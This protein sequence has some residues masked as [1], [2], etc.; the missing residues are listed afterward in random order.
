MIKIKRAQLK[1]YQTKI[2]KISDQLK[3][4]FIC[5]CFLRWKKRKYININEKNISKLIFEK[6]LKK[7]HT[8]RFFFKVSNLQFFSILFLHDLI[9]IWKKNETFNLKH[10]ICQSIVSFKIQN[11]VR[12]W[13]GQTFSNKTVFSLGDMFVIFR[14]DFNIIH[15]YKRV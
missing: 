14:G 1:L 7:S 10:C 11:A 8:I 3:W 2:T 6:N 9:L 13:G 12:L 5:V 4:L 15:L